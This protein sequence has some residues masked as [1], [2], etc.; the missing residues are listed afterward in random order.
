[1]SWTPTRTPRSSGKSFT[2][3]SRAAPVLREVSRSTTLSSPSPPPPPGRDG[4]GEADEGAPVVAEGEA[5]RPESPDPSGC[6]DRSAVGAVLTPPPASPPAP[7]SAPPQAVTRRAEA[8]AIAVMV[9]RGV[10]VRS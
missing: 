5:L 6:P 9:V 7:P 4:D 2:P 1:M 3:A 8:R 10:T